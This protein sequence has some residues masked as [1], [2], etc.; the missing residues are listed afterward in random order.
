MKELKDRSFV[1]V[2][3][4]RGRLTAPRLAAEGRGRRMQQPA[5]PRHPG[6]RRDRLDRLKAGSFTI[7]G[8]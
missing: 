2:K 7:F 1:Y 6:R 8:H 4:L 3:R 5:R